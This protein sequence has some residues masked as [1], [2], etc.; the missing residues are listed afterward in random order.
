MAEAGRQFWSSSGPT[1]LLR[2]PELVAQ[3]HVQTAFEYV[4]GGRLYNLPGYVCR[5]IPGVFFMN[6]STERQLMGPQCLFL[7]DIYRMACL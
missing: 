6:L 1:H 5:D 4:Q 7:K 3:D 2:L